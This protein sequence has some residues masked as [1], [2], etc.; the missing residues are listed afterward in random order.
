MKAG[1]KSADAPSDASPS[2]LAKYAE[3]WRLPGAETRY[4]DARRPERY[5]RYKQEDAVVGR[6][7]RLCPPGSTVLDV[8]CG[9]GR[10]NELVAAMGHRVIR[11]DLSFQMVA[12]AQKLGPNTH[13]IGSLCFDVARPPLRPR[14]VDAVLVWRFFH[15]CRT[16]ED[17][18]L[19]LMQAAAL[20]QRYVILSFYNR[21]C[22]TYWTRRITRKLLG[23][24]P[25]CRGAIWTRE[26]HDLAA[27]AGLKPVEIH[28]YH[29]GFSINSAACF[30]V[31]T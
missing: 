18:L 25:K 12:H 5:R 7:L 28:H 24:A 27:R 4:A 31:S 26:L 2:P 3:H 11:A 14:S 16:P 19:V 17:R 10:F 23:R 6:W 15:H 21:E 30:R 8:P 22:V 29:R 9:T 20:A 1:L 13:A